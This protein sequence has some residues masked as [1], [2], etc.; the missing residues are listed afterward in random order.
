[1]IYLAWHQR[2]GFLFLQKMKVLVLSL[3]PL[4]VYADEDETLL[5][6][7]Q[8]GSFMYIAFIV[9]WIIRSQAVRLQLFA[10][11]L[12]LTILAYLFTLIPYFDFDF[13]STAIIRTIVPVITTIILVIFIGSSRKT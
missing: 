13:I 8:I 3:W 11:Y 5:F 2:S 4:P 6:S 10:L 1:M 9:T 12:C 7:M